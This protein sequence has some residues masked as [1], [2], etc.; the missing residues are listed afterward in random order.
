VATSFSTTPA[1]KPTAQERCRGYQLES[2][3]NHHEIV[4]S[5]FEDHAASAVKNGGA[6]S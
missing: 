3:A 2:S 5:E 4:H 1:E 6:G